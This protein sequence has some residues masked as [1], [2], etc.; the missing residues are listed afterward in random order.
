MKHA[1]CTENFNSKKVNS[2]KQKF[3]AKILLYNLS[4]MTCKAKIDKEVNKERKE[5]KHKCKTNKR[6]LLAMFK[7]RSA[8][9]FFQ[10]YF[11]IKMNMESIINL[12]IKESIP[13][14]NNREY[15]RGS[16]YKVKKKHYRAYVPVC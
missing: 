2:I 13:I 3:F 12:V 11:Q 16:S 10:N 15:P 7:Q 4:M 8:S 6:A 1:I 14:R 9:L 5:K